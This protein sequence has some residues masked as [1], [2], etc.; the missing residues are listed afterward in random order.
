[1]TAAGSNLGP[2]AKARSV[3]LPFPKQQMPALFGALPGG[4]M[5]DLSELIW[6]CESRK[7]SL[8]HLTK[9]LQENYSNRT[10]TRQR[11]YL[12]KR[13]QRIL[14]PVTPSMKIIST[15]LIA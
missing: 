3:S 15:A 5:K 6:N 4:N 7:L 1:M 14:Q 8:P 9:L 12:M 13:C 11:G 2:A 10:R